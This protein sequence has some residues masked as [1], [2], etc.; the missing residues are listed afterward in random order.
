MWFLGSFGPGI[1]PTSIVFSILYRSGRGRFK[2]TKYIAPAEYGASSNGLNQSMFSVKHKL[3]G[4]DRNG[5][6]DT[7]LRSFHTFP[8]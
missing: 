8:S 2:T 7:V 5:L 4:R 3:P 6:P 1:M